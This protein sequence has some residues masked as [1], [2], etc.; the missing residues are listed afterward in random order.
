VVYPYEVTL[1]LS[2]WWYILKVFELAVKPTRKNMELVGGCY[3]SAI[4]K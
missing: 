4:K 3:V 2:G 1:T